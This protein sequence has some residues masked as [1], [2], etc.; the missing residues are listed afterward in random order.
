MKLANLKV[1]RLYGRGA[2]QAAMLRTYNEMLS[3]RRNTF[4]VSGRRSL[5]ATVHRFIHRMVNDRN[6]DRVM[7]PA[8]IMIKDHQPMP[9][10]A[11]IATKASS[12]SG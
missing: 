8:A 2:S 10:N 9:A 5:D 12:Q 1:M 3:Y 4:K 7:G 11:A 6:A